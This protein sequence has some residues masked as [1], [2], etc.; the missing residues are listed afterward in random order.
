MIISIVNIKNIP[1]AALEHLDTAETVAQ[2]I[3][4]FSLWRKESG[5]SPV[6]EKRSF[7]VTHSNPEARVAEKFRFDICAEI[8][9]E[10]PENDYGVRNS[11]IAAGRYARLR[12]KGAL[13]TIDLK[14]NALSRNWLPTTQEC[15]GDSPIFFEYLNL[16]SAVPDSERMTDIYFPLR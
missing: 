16:S 13:D 7:G 11:E 3:E 12:H 4:K 1:V 10:I 6:T 14:V 8:D 15:R 5:C 9:A 2:S